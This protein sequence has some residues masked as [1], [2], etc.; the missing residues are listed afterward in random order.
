MGNSVKRVAPAPAPAPVHI[1][2]T[3][4]SVTVHMP[5]SPSA[6][7]LYKN[8]SFHSN[9]EEARF[10]WTYLNDFVSMLRL[11]KIV[12]DQDSVESYKLPIV[13]ITAVLRSRMRKTGID[14]RNVTAADVLKYRRPDDVRLSNTELKWIDQILHCMRDTTAVLFV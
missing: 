12:V 8:Y 3:L 7:E 4:Q 9:Q 5:D 2:P 11:L 6:F 1:S 10:V 14:A 13:R